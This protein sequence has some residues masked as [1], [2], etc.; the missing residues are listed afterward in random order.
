M[1]FE[2]VD[3]QT[4]QVKRRRILELVVPYSSSL[5]ARFFVAFFSFIIEDLEISVCGFLAITH[6][7]H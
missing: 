2:I 7:N 5:C 3:S 4:A 6:E 1:P